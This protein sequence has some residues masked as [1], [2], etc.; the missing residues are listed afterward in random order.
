[1][2]AVENV[3]RNTVKKSV[4]KLNSRKGTTL[5]ETLCAFLIIVLAMTML[6]N[7]LL[8]ACDL[9]RTGEEMQ[10]QNQGV[11]QD[12]WSG[13]AVN[14]KPSSSMTL[15]FDGFKIKGVTLNG[16]KC[17]YHTGETDEY[18]AYIYDFSK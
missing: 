3:I 4:K 16:Y 11:V 7:V 12:Y 14:E 5:A 2:K 8:Q 13:A 15:N 1:M 10:R 18:S 6:C 9:I 17:N